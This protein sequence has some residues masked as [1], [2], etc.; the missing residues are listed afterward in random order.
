MS[1]LPAIPHPLFLLYFIESHF[2]LRRMFQLT[3]F[4]H[5]SLAFF[6]WTA[7]A[8]PSRLELTLVFFFLQM[9]DE[10]IP[11]FYLLLNRTID[12][13]INY[14]WPSVGRSRRIGILG[15]RLQD[16]AVDPSDNCYEP[17]RSSAAVDLYTTWRA[18]RSNWE[19]L[20]VKITW[21]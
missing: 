18:S 10:C 12:L 3:D 17:F 14:P 2:Q 13:G 20:R 15:G 11:I 6:R 16:S 19:A 7:K 4:W 8:Y 9:F 21:D 1:S 5:W